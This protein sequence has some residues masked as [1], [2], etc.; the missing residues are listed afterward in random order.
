M[1]LS[2]ILNSNNLMSNSNNT[3]CSN[4]NCTIISAIAST[5]ATIR[6]RPQPHQQSTV[7]TATASISKTSISMYKIW[8]C[9]LVLIEAGHFKFIKIYIF[10]KQICIWMLF[11]NNLWACIMFI[12]DKVNIIILWAGI[13]ITVMQITFSILLW[14][15]LPWIDLSHRMLLSILMI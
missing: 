12:V 10:P 5:T 7:A 4:D 15:F 1:R 11:R 13:C 6:G 8:D 14:L 3:N 2:S 9:F